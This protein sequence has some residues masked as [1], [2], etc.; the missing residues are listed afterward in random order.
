MNY[1]GPEMKAKNV[2]TARVADYAT[3]RSQQ[4][5][6]K[7]IK[8]PV[9]NSEINRETD[10]IRSAFNLAKKRGKIQIVPDIE[11]LQEPPAR[12]GFFEYKQFVFLLTFLPFAVAQLCRF[13]YITGWRL[14]EGKGL[15]WDHI[16]FDARRIVLPGEM[17]KNGKPR[18][19]PFTPDLESLLREQW[20]YTQQCQKDK[21]TLIPYVFHREGRQIREF[22]R[23]WKSAC[24]KAGL[25]TAIVHSFRRTA[26]RNLEIAGVPRAVAMQMVGLET[27]STYRRYRIVSEGEFQSAAETMARFEKRR[28]A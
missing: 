19:F 22:K 3:H 14:E 11:R 25:A 7:V 1:F 6:G 17:T 23:S 18:V 26:V 20:E 15:L 27:E 21:V 24:E 12:S 2:T 4:T 13:Y 8:K 5:Y 16:S 28:K 9:S 10:L